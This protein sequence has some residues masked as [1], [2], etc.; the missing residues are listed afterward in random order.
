MHAHASTREGSD[1]AAAVEGSRAA[2]GSR[3]FKPGLASTLLVGNF[4]NCSSR[5][6][7]ITVRELIP[8]KAPA[9]ETPA[10]SERRGWSTSTCSIPA[11]QTSSILFVPEGLRSILTFHQPK[12]SSGTHNRARDVREHASIR[13]SLPSNPCKDT[14]R[15]CAGIPAYLN[16]PR[17]Q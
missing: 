6:L 17:S 16:D 8:I 9:R 4:C 14:A 13:G 2:L 10:R 7:A 12:R 11:Q 3:G 5:E 15:A 1:L